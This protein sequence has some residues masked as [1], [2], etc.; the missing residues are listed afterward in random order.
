MEKVG[1]LKENGDRFE[2]HFDQLGLIIRGNYP[3]WV[4]AAASE[5]IRDSAKIDSDSRMEELSAL[6]EFGEA[7]E[8]DVDAHKVDSKFRFEVLPQCV[9]TMGSMDYRWADEEARRKF[10]AEFGGHS[11][12]RLHD[13]SM[14]RNDS[15]LENEEGVDM[16]SEETA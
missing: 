6:V 2:F 10:G 3:E 5:I 1:Y 15:F 14:T 4:L 9:V 11:M 13:M 16:S 7:S 8:I 12:R